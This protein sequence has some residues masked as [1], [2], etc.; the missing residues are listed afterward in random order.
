M[1]HERRR[2]ARKLVDFGVRMFQDRRAL[3]NES[4]VIDVG[5]GGFSLLAYDPIDPGE[6]LGFKIQLSEDLT[7]SGSAKV[8]WRSDFGPAGGYLHG[9][10]FTK[11][12]FF[13]RRRLKAFLNPSRIRWIDVLDMGLVA[14]VALVGIYAL[15]DYWAAHDWAENTTWA[16]APSCMIVGLLGW[17]LSA[18]SRSV[19]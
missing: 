12:G 11:I 7:I 8:Q 6:Q 2:A 10:Q 9:A 14:A 17:T 5:S 4:R 15:R 13:D 18:K 3:G 1:I 16:V 19:S